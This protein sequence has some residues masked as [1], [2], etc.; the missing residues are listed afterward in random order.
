MNLFSSSPIFPTVA[1]SYLT[2]CKSLR[3]TGQ[4]TSA[5]LCVV[6]HPLIQHY[7]LPPMPSLCG[8]KEAIEALERPETPNQVGSAIIKA[9]NV[10]VNSAADANRAT[11]VN[12]TSTANIV[13][14]FNQG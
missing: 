2:P 1:A 9:V 10:K 11:N 4:L 13:V 5:N 7:Y 3:T 12:R 6:H 8:L 14:N